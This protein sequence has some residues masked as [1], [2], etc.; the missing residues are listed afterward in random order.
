MEVDGQDKKM[1]ILLRAYTH[2]R[3]TVAN[4]HITS[5]DDSMKSAALYQMKGGRFNVDSDLAS[6]GDV[7]R[8]ENASVR[9]GH[10]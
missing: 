6:L 5:A 1:S 7:V 2:G 8:Y 4:A 3:N 9:I 10:I